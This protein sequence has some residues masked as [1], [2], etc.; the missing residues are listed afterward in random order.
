MVLFPKV[1]VVTAEPFQFP[2]PNGFP[3]PNDQALEELF[4]RAGGNFTNA[5]LA[6]KFDSDSLTSWKL[7]AFN[8]FFEVAFFTQLIANISRREPGY[9]LDSP[10]REYI[11]D[12]LTTIQAQEEMHAYNANDA[13]RYFDNGSHIFPCT[14]QFPV[15]DFES[16]IALAQTFTDMYIGLLANIQQ[17]TARN[18]GTDSN[19]IVYVLAQALGQEGQQSG[20]FRSLQHKPPSA[21]PFLTSSTRELAFSWI[22]R[23]IVPG[24]CP[25]MEVIPLRI[26]PRLDATVEKGDRG[27]GGE[28]E[29]ILV[30]LRVPGP[31]DPSSQSVAYVNGAL[32]PTV[33]PFEV[34]NTSGCG[35]G[36]EGVLVKNWDDTREAV[37]GT[38]ACI[39]STEIVASLPYR[40]NVMHGM[41]LATIVHNGATFITAEDV[42]N[43]TVYGPAVIELS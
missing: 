27:K 43:A 24:S 5:P 10:A 15:S 19:S 31:V 9:D 3:F 26:F 4:I 28:E 23:F 41:I 37:R 13:V 2:L 12:S 20:W 6:P 1:Q 34:R 32:V 14:Y 25:N 39:Q 22:Q 16:A 21:E 29:N 17:L 33:V 36:H 18:L 11:L 8:E 7:Q 42:T 35:H 38:A 30:T 40:H